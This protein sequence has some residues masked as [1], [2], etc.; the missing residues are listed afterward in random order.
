[1]HPALASPVGTASA[2]NQNPWPAGGE[3]A[4]ALQDTLQN[5]AINGAAVAVLGALFLRDIKGQ[6]KDRTVIEREE[7]L[8]RLQVPSFKPDKFLPVDELAGGTACV[9]ACDCFDLKHACPMA[10]SDVIH[11]C[12]VGSVAY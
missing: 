1:M 2:V 11:V 12:H 7:K 9:H 4:P 3:G 10:Q 6:Q 5:L 8:A